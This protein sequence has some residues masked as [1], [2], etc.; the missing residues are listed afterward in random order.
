MN[1][2]KT[3]RI[4]L[5]AGGL[6]VL[7]AG[8]L[9]VPE[10][11][12]ARDRHSGHDHSRRAYDDRRDY[13]RAQQKCASRAAEQTDRI[14]GRHRAEAVASDIYSDCMRRQGFEVR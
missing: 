3:A 6:S 5:A 2:R 13:D 7:S 14:R 4:I 10:P 11:P 1:L 9:A 12:F 8:C